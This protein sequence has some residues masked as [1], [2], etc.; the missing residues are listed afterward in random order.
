MSRDVFLDN[1]AEVDA[2]VKQIHQLERKAHDQGQ[3]IGICHPYPETLTALRQELPKLRERGFTI[4]PV[5][6]LL[7]KKSSAQGS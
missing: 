6:A 1:V 4:V 7:R 2:I 3:A 5:S